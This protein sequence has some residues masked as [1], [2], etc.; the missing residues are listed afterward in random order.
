[1]NERTVFQLSRARGDESSGNI[2]APRTLIV[3]E[4]SAENQAGTIMK[5]PALRAAFN[6]KQPSKYHLKP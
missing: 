1:L 6:I 5:S 2:D 4:A 3:A